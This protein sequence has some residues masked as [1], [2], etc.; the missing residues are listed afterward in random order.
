MWDF[1]S[2]HQHDPPR[3]TRTDLQTELFTMALDML[4]VL[5]AHEYTLTFQLTQFPADYPEAYHFP[6]NVKANQ[7]TYYNR[8]WT[9]TEATIASFVK[10]QN[11]VLDLG[12]VRYDAATSALCTRTHYSQTLLTTREQILR[13]CHGARK[14]PLMPDEFS[15]IL[16]K[17]SFTNGKDDRP[18]VAKIQEKAFDIAFGGVKQLKYN[19]LKWDAEGAM[20]IASVL[21]SG[22]APELEELHLDDNRI[23]DQGLKRLAADMLQGPEGGNRCSTVPKLRILSLR[24]CNITSDG[25]FGLKEAMRLGA[26]PSLEKLDV[27]AN[28]FSAKPREEREQEDQKRSLELVEACKL[29]GVS[30]TD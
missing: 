14:P 16:D 17:L 22:A 18:R 6:P 7:E 11:M 15:K 4:P 2:M 21:A 25:I 9:H 23:D 29:W 5:Y 20:A 30:I 12:K 26:L 24:N 13:A 19:H 3:C 10:N 27:S 1:L 28:P 8:G